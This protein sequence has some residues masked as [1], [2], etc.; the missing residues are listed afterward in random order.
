MLT[1]SEYNKIVAD[2]VT[3]E[4]ERL[5]ES[6][7]NIFKRKGHTPDALIQAVVQ[8]VENQPATAARVVTEILDS[9]GFLPDGSE[10]PDEVSRQIPY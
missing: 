6:L 5:V 8:A 9:L 4:R 10:A 1:R 7:N 3:N 2:I